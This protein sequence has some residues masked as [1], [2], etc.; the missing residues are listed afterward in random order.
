MLVP[1]SD[2][3]NQY[4]VLYLSCLGVFGGAYS[5]GVTLLKKASRATLKDLASTLSL[6]MTMSNNKY[7]HESHCVNKH[8]EA[9]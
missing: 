1:F 2:Q 9:Q 6:L 4:N 5:P 3:Y 7:D 8:G